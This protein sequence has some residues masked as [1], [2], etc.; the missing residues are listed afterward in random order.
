MLLSTGPAAG[1]ALRLLARQTAGMA[2]PPD[3]DGL[4]RLLARQE[5]VITRGQA[6]RFL[7]PKTLRHRLESGRWQSGHRAVFVAH[8]GPVHRRQREWVAVLATGAVLGGVSALTRLGMRGYDEDSVHVLLSARHRVVD[9]P[10][11]VVVHRTTVLPYGQVLRW[12]RPPATKAA[13]SLVDAA[14]W[15]ERDDRARAL[16]AAA[17]QQRLVA[18]DE[19]ARMLDLMPVAR[20]RALIRATAEDARAGS[21]SIAE[22]DFLGLCRRAALP[23]P[24]RQSTRTDSDGR[25]RYRDAYF[26]PWGVHVEIDGGQHLEVRTWWADM[27]RQNDLWIRGDRVLR[28]PAWAV[29]ERPREVATQVRAALL[30][31]GWPGG[32]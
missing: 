24:T 25:R 5:S 26:E 8:N 12:G 9:P 22:V 4:V 1:A 28:F 20:R 6:L 13:R 29:R 10:S 3:P 17:Y 14:S 31:A 7:S 15:A 30:A 2:T 27:K 18:G 16:V 32:G 23:L 21:H 11:G 19:V